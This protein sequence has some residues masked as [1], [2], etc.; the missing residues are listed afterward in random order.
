MASGD[1]SKK[2]LAEA[3]NALLADYYALYLK[4]KNFHWHITGPNF[5][6]YHLLFDEQ[7]TELIA[8]TDLVAER[9][10]KLGQYTLTSI[11]SI[12]AIQGIKDHDS[13][14]TDAAMML[15]E[16][17]ADNETL[18]RALKAA[19]DLADEAGDN[20]TDGLLDDWTD[21]AE[22]RAWFLAATMGNA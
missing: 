9:V 5:R 13:T 17:H 21:Q 14:S 20:A 12:A 2:A 19:K 10:R 6:E 18:I 15:K 22:Q 7:A 16:L 8:T 11:G 1:N 3:L 4:T